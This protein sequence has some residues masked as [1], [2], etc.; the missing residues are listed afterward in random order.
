MF[1]L[2]FLLPIMLAT[3]ASSA[4]GPVIKK[5]AFGKTPDGK[6]VDIYTLTNSHGMEVRAMTYGGIVVSLRVPDKQ[7]KLADVVLGFDN[8]DGYLD[9]KPYMGA[10][11]GRYGN[12]I[13]GA[14]FRLD[15]VKY[16]LAKNNG[17][18]SL[19]GGLKG[20]DKVV[21][22]AHSS[23]GPQ[24][25][26][27]TFTYISKNGEEGF[28][29][30]LKAKVTYTLNNKNELIFDYQAT[31]DKAT[32]VNLTNHSYFNLSGE[33]NGDILKHEVRLNADRFTPV[34]DN[35]IPTG[36]LQS[37]K[38]GD[39]GTPLDFTKSTPIGARINADY[40]QLVIA[41]G[42]DHNFV[43]NRKG[44]GMELAARVKDPASGRV[45]EV[46]TTEPGVQFYTGNF[47]DGTITGKQGHVYKQ[48]YG[49]CLETQ[50]YPDSPNHPDFPSTIL[51]PGQ[52]YHSETMLKF[53]AE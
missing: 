42:Y 17:P 5:E 47:L 50:H 38:Q 40:Q 21:W 39:G 2:G 36:E 35:L 29:G 41:K 51:R 43:I 7:G 11:I 32:P 19:H 10:I 31:A 53:S 24:G 27:V 48:R 12:R 37:V 18:N 4:G 30:T 25:Q 45:L 3:L 46:F 28:P 44:D 52:T 20:F 22:D 33:G 1:V 49:F 15:G 16:T 13:G 34:D 26:S 23:E 9:N 8:F 6:T 14:E